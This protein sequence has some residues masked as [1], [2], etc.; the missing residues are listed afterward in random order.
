VEES[1]KELVQE[2]EQE[3]EPVKEETMELKDFEVKRG[4]K[5]PNQMAKLFKAGYRL[6]SENDG[7]MYEVIGSGNS[8][9]WKLVH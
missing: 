6:K 7:N 4:K 5:V 8:K 3:P 1:V 2:P 9:K